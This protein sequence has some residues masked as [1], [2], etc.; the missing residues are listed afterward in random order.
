MGLTLEKPGSGR[1]FFLPIVDQQD[2][3]HGRLF[4]Q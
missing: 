3:Q 4:S 1:A 2:T